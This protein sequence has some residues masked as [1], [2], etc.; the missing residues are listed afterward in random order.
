MRVVARTG[1]APKRAPAP[2]RFELRPAPRRKAGHREAW[3]RWIMFDRKRGLVV[4][5]YRSKH[6]ANRAL[7]V[8][9]AE[10]AS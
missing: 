2:P 8:R 5:T 7:R 6:V 1:R 10:G 3:V 4:G 9:A